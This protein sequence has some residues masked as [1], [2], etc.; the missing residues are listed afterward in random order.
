MNLICLQG[1]RQKTKK[2]TE[3]IKNIEARHEETERDRLEILA[4][5]NAE[6]ESLKSDLE[7]CEAHLF[8][9]L[10]NPNFLLT[11]YLYNI[12]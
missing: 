11:I 10:F 7:V 1:R 4:S 12:F 8:H 9:K 2:Y 6:L 3:K 5:K